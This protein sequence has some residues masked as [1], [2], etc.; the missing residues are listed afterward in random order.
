ML[1]CYNIF[2][3]RPFV[4]ILATFSIFI[5]NAIKDLYKKMR[6]QF[7]CGFSIVFSRMAVA[8]ET[9]I[10]PHQFKEP[11]IAQRVVGI[12]ANSLYLSCVTFT[13][14]TGFFCR[15]KKEENYLPDPCTKYSLFSCRWLS[16]LAHSPQIFIQHKFNVGEK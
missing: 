8:G 11:L 15:Y 4:R 16:Y 9:S 7:T 1:V 14:P 10:H 5:L 2:D 13:N 6:S 12:D 3:S